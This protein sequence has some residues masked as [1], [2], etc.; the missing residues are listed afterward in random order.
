MGL[1]L[2]FVCNDDIV[3][4]YTDVN[5]E[6]TLID[7]ENELQSIEIWSNANNLI[8][9]RTIPKCMLITSRF[10]FPFILRMAVLDIEV[11]HY[12]NLSEIL[13]D[14]LDFDRYPLL[15]LTMLILYWSLT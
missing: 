7:L 2:F 10:H 9:K 8:I 4:C 1:I 6:V 3:V 14:N 5:F 13:Q 12:N 11:K 15:P